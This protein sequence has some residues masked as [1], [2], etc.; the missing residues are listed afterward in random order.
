MSGVTGRIVSMALL[1]AGVIGLDLLTKWWARAS[2]TSAPRWVASGLVRLQFVENEGAFMGL[3]Q[4]L[5]ASSRA[6]VVMAITGAVL[7]VLLALALRAAWGNTSAGQRLGLALIAGGGL[8][9][10]IDRL[11]NDGAVSDFVALGQGVVRTGFFNLAD[12]TIFAGIALLVLFRPSTTAVTEP[13][14]IQEDG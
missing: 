11:L 6:T 4:S 13:T 5:P 14:E 7:L 3:G 2:L 10:W 8:G 9:N 12:V 1:I